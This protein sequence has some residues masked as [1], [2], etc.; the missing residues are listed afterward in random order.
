MHNPYCKAC[1]GLL[2]KALL[3]L[4]VAICCLGF[5]TFGEVINIRVKELQVECLVKEKISRE[6]GA[7]L[8]LGALIGLLILIRVC[9]QAF[10]QNRML[11]FDSPAFIDQLCFLTLAEFDSSQHKS[12]SSSCSFVT[13]WPTS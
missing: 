6:T 11:A 2:E 10:E 8:E 3:W 4:M 13:S 7:A 5:A 9:V 1:L 12:Q